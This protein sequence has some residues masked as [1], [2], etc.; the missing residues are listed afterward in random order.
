MSML[1]L[2]VIVLFIGAVSCG[3]DDTSSPDAGAND[4]SQEED[5]D[6]SKP[7][8]DSGVG[9]E[10][11]DFAIAKKDARCNH[12]GDLACLSHNGGERVVCLDGTWKVSTNAAACKAAERCDTKLGSTQGTCRP[13]ITECVDKQPGAAVCDGAERKKCDKDLL[14]YEDD[15]CAGEH[16]M[17]SDADDKVTCICASGYTDDNGKCVAVPGCEN[18]PCGDLP[19]TCGEASDGFSCMCGSGFSGTGTKTCDDINECATDNGGCD[20]LTDCTNTAGG[21]TCSACPAG[22]TGDGAT[23]CVETNECNTNN[24]GC[25]ALTTCTNTPGGRTCGACPSGYTGDGASGCVDINECSTNNGGC[26]SHAP[27]TNT[28]GA[29]TCG[30]CAEFYLGT[31]DTLCT[32]VWTE[33]TGTDGADNP[34]AVTTDATGN[35]YVTGY[36]S[37]GF[38]STTNAGGWDVFVIKYN[39]AGAT[40]WVKQIGTAADDVAYGI[41]VDSTGNVYVGGTTAGNL[42]GETNSGNRDIFL[43]KYDSTGMLLWSELAGT[44]VDDY[45][46][47]ISTTMAGDTYIAGATA[48]DLAGTSAGGYDAVLIKYNTAGT[49]QWT[50]QFGTSAEDVAQGVVFAG[51][52][53][54]TGT[55]KGDLDGTNFGGTDIFLR[56]FDSLG[57]VAWTAQ[58]GSTADDYSRTLASQ[59]GDV[60][61]V[62]TSNG[63]FDGGTNAGYLDAILVK[64]GGD[65]TEA[66]SQQIGT[67]DYD[68]ANG[69]S[70]DSDGNVYIAGYSN[71]NFDG[72]TSVGGADIV[73]V[74]YDGAGAK[75][76]SRQIGTTENDLGAAITT[77]AAG[78]LI[79]TGS[80][81][82][83]L[84]GRTNAGDYDGFVTKYDASGN[85]L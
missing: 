2:G 64:Y 54:V 40:Q 81:K 17:C 45:V 38:D 27:C 5:K 21:R 66:W 72:H 61:I 84:D 31:G 69:V 49:Q 34:Q 13:V 18:K 79:I 15:A 26:D 1:R 73:L 43:L 23:G 16:V 62:G 78:A 48:G 67:A 59:G 22:Y 46:L 76:W 39:S 83:A 4:A 63:D 36:T 8:A 70:A 35:V 55:T 57:D 80:T 47:G 85:H 71:S 29:R 9:E 12:D 56:K 68:Y 53:Y 20:A 37:G 41:G 14:R 77:N 58:I 24:G 82:G 7:A 30:A 3:D 10:L 50:R 32:H 52:A 60:F 65:G 19:N 6:A 75:Q 42:D 28:P 11:K 25:D 51:D 74:K 33:V 44:A